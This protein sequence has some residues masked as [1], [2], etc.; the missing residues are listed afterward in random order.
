MI[1]IYYCLLGK[2]FSY[3]N[4]FIKIEMNVSFILRYAL[5]FAQTQLEVTYAAV[6]P[7]TNLVVTVEV[8]KVRCDINITVLQMI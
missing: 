4:S 2:I 6:M 1:D 3:R 8:V 7:V 5:I